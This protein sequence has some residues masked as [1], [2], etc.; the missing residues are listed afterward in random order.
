MRRWVPV[1]LA[2]TVVLVPAA[3]RAQTHETHGAAAHETEA[4]EPAPRAAVPSAPADTDHGTGDAVAAVKEA[5]SR[6]SQPAPAPARSREEIRAATLAAA[7]A[8]ASPRA[9][10]RRSAP[11]ARRP[12]R[13]ARRYAVAWPS[14]DTVW[15]VTWPEDATG[16]L[17]LSWP[18]ASFTSTEDVPLDGSAPPSARGETPAV[19]DT[20]GKAGDLPA[21]PQARDH[22][23]PQ[24]RD[25]E[26]LPERDPHGQEPVH[27]AHA[28]VPVEAPD[29]PVPGPSH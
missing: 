24:T 7:R 11:A 16:A 2:L 22:E 9:S 6:A 5:V 23:A 15:E 1:V 8:A 3:G 13:P 12:A 17:T 28:G 14:L 19:P 20:V 10:A 18:M 4:H 25:H 26:T 29:A 21:T 27:E